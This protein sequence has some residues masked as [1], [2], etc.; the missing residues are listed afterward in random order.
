MIEAFLWG[1]I[2]ASSL[3]IGS[4]LALRASIPQRT[5]GLVMG[6]GAG[7]LLSA[8]AYDLVLDATL[9][10]TS[11]VVVFIG[12]LTGAFVFFLGNR[13][14]ERQSTRNG[15]AGGQTKRAGGTALILGA[16]LDGIPESIVLGLTLISGE[17]IGITVLIAILLSNLPEGIAGT[18][19]LV[20][21]GWTDAR[22]TRT[23]TIVVVA[24]AF[25]SFAGYAVFGNASPDTVAFV[26]GFAGGA[27]IA[28]LTDSMIPEAYENGGNLVGLVT[29]VGFATAFALTLLEWLPRT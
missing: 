25:A 23:W 9:S 1:G 21:T 5:V 20:E 19:D 4:L 22:I 2:A 7:V 29:A 15:K 10:E 24:C 27:I 26:Q 13:Y 12:L 8:V 6:F 17:G 3:L 18:H 28:M 11:H 16:V 14:L